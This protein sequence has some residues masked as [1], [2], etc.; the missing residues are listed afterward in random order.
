MKQVESNRTV[1]EVEIVATDGKKHE[2]YIDVASA[3][4]LRVED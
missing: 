4:V 3:K 2:V 1:C